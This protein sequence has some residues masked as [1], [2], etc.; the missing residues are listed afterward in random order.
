MKKIT[1]VSLLLIL[2]N[3]TSFSQTTIFTDDFSTHTS[4][5]WTSSGSIGS[6][7]FTVNRSGVDWGARRNTSPEQ[8]E[9]INDASGSSNVNGWCFAYIDMDTSASYSP[10]F[11]SMSGNID[12]YFNMRQIRTDPAGFSSGSYGVAFIIGCT[13]TSPFNSGNGY[14]VVLGQSGT[15]DPI[16]LARFTGG[17]SGTLTN[18]ITASSPLNDIGNQYLSL[19]INLDRSTNTWTLYG[20][21]DGASSFT[22]P[23]VGTLTNLGN[24]TDATYIDGTTQ[25]RYLGGYWQG[26]TTANQTAFFDNISIDMENPLPVE[27][28]SF[29][30]I[31]FLNSIKLVWS[32]STETN[33]YGFEIER[34]E[35][36][37]YWDKI[38]FVAGNGNSN[39]PKEYSF[40]DDKLNKSGKYYYRLKQLD[41][42]GGFEYSNVIEVDF[43]LVNDFQLHQNFPNPFNPS[44]RISWQ[45][46]VSGW[47]TIKLFDVLGREVETIVDG[48]YEAGKH[49]TLYIVNSTLPSGI[50][51]YQL[52]AGGFSQSR[53]MLLVK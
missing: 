13:S 12:W 27:L 3:I 41:I 42:D 5:S 38:G 50:Y 2:F 46:P 24:A 21:D 33:N 53:K 23:K 4:T 48:F 1:L 26:S 39:S 19:R 35:N 14:A 36:N 7:V 18:I 44:T 6:S 10:N 43:V 11:Q 30:S 9:L 45:S 22:N 15:T 29:L 32:T 52:N 34:S 40:I 20:R 47:Q 51:Y 17:L 37:F 25:L 8:L 16:R 28:S 49:S 31:N